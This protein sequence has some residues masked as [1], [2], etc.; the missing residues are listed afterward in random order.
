[1]KSGA[2]KMKKRVTLPILCFC[3]AASF[4]AAAGEPFSLTEGSNV[5]VNSEEKS[6]SLAVS[7]EE[8]KGAF[9]VFLKKDE[10]KYAT[11]DVTATTLNSL[12]PAA[13]V[14]FRI[15]F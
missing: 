15:E 5:H 9:E 13:G 3:V 10:V 8:K 1:M 11:D 2:D 14:Q 4:S 12:T 6:V 7:G